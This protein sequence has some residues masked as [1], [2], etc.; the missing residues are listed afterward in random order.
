VGRLAALYAYRRVVAPFDG[1]ITSRHVDRGA[2]VKAAA[3]P[4]YEIA[5]TRTL[6]V[7][8]DVPQSLAGD[9]QPGLT[10]EVFA[11][12]APTRVTPGKVV[13]TAGA[14]DPGTRTLRTEIHLPGG[15]ALLAGAF[16]RV[17]L[18]VQRSA[19][20]VVVPAAALSLRKEGPRVVVLLADRRVKQQAV[21]PGRDLGTE[22]ELLGGLDGGERVVLSP[23]DDLQ[24]GAQV[25]VAEA[26][27]GK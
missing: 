19:A 4:L 25:D 16:V 24:D 10:A 21:I 18:E 7:F 11:P 8:V 23:P 17:R 9:V 27:G 22:I 26:P 15:G 12:E 13:R 2:L 14:L 3:T 20:P 5:Q 1:V 6:K